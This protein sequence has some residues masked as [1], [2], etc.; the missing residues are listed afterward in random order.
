MTTLKLFDIEHAWGL[1]RKVSP[2]FGARLIL[3][4]LHLDYLHDRASFVGEF[5][6]AIKQQFV[7]AFPSMVKQLERL[8]AT[9]EIDATKQHCVSVEYD[10]FTCEADTLGS[11]GY[12][13]I[14]VYQTADKPLAALTHSPSIT[15]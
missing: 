11:H 13:Y 9:G 6:P 12:L 7:E 4:G 15:L 8:V 14:A 3:R 2:R 5:P 1:P 10:D